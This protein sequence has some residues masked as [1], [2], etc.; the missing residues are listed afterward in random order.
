MKLTVHFPNL[1]HA[2]LFAYPWQVY[3]LAT[4]NYDD[5]SV[6]SGFPATKL[7]ELHGNVYTESCIACGV[8]YRRD[9]EVS[10]SI[11][12]FASARVACRSWQLGFFFFAPVREAIEPHAMM[13]TRVLL[14]ACKH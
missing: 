10:W 9:F 8:V 14:A 11:R 12:H 6:R 1:F 3:W 7:S 2:L 5:L 13:A 4:Q